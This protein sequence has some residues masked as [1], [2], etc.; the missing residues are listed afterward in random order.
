[1]IGLRIGYLRNGE[2]WGVVGWGYRD[3]FGDSTVWLSVEIGCRGLFRGSYRVLISSGEWGL[4]RF[5]FD[6][7]IG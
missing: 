7:G 2:L 3:F 6:G 1:M 5:R 4:L